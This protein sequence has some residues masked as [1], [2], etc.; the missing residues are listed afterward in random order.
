MSE[1]KSVVKD[2][3]E[4]ALGATIVAIAIP[5]V[6]TSLLMDKLEQYRKLLKQMDFNP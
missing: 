6:F 5:F 3:L 2:C 1:D 4:L